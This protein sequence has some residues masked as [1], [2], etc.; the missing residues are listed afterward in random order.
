MLRLL[1]PPKC[2]LCKTILS[3]SETDLCHNCRKEA[4]KF[5]RAKSNIPFIA[6]WTALWYYKDNVRQ[7]IHRF[8]FGNRRNYAAAYARL[9]G[10]R[11]LEVYSESFDILTWVPVS[12]LR[13]LKRGY[14]QSALLA[15][16]LGQELGVPA[17][18]VLKKIRHT[19]PQS[20]LKDAS[21]RRANVLGA[22]KTRTNADLS[23]K[24][25]LL[26]DDVVT[27]GATASE[28]A[29][30]LLGAGA[31]EVCFAAVAAAFHDKK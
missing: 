28:C 25:I 19:P 15:K 24:R 8:K 14:D 23:G 17:T 2:V 16:T 11:L 9:L 5:S 21:A 6:H 29:K 26:L 4:P 13:K 22:Y 10:V 3:G 20:L 31:K 30:M 12:G 7:S 27:T 18:D 1:F